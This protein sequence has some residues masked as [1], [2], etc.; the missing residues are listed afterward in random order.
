MKDA[1]GRCGGR[2]KSALHAVHCGV[3]HAL[4][5]AASLSVRSG[6]QVESVEIISDQLNLKLHYATPVTAE[7]RQAKPHKQYAAHLMDLAEA[8]YAH[9]DGA[10]LRLVGTTALKNDPIRGEGG[11]LTGLG[12]EAM[13]AAV[14]SPQGC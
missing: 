10:N 2:T 8:G 3:V 1:S 13:A 5:F 11:L 7:S 14:G 6:G 9:L 12:G 4:E